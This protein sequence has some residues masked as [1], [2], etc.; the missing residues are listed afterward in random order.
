VLFV[1]SI[2]R[3]ILKPKQNRL[4]GYRTR[5]TLSDKKAWALSN[6]VFALVSLFFSAFEIVAFALLIHFTIDEIGT[7]L[8]FLCFL[9]VLTVYVSILITELIVRKADKI[10]TNEDR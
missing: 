2:L 5:Q 7:P 4:F 1:L 8:I 10:S 3:L 9:S 6:F